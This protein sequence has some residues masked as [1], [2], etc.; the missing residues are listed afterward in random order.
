MGGGGGREGRC[1][2]HL[3]GT[4]DDPSFGVKSHGAGCNGVLLI[5]DLNPSTYKNPDE[6]YC[7][8]AQ[9]LENGIHFAARVSVSTE[10]PGGTA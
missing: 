4:L 3:M 5:P 10:E 6:Y 2:Q 1:N 8:H 9:A 7:A